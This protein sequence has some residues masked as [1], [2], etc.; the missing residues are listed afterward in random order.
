VHWHAIFIELK[1]YKTQ[2]YNKNG[3]PKKA[4][5]QAQNQIDMWR[6]W[7]RVNEP[8]LRQRF[9]EILEKED[10]PAIWPHKIPNYTS[11]Y[12]SG[13]KEIADHKKLCWLLLPHSYRTDVYSNRRRKKI[14]AK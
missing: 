9:S 3:N 10:A 8:Y 14:S 13:A 6:E 5:R 1:D 2:L 4:L 12:S 11:G 7:I